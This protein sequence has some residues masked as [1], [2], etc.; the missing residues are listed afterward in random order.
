MCWKQ[1]CQHWTQR[2]ALRCSYRNRKGNICK[3]V[4]T[5]WY[6]DNMWLKVIVSWIR[7]LLEMRSG[8]TTISQSQ[9]SSPWSGNMWIPHWRKK[10]RCSL[11]R[12]K[13]CALSLG[14]EKG[15]DPSGFP[16]IISSDHYIMMLTKL[17]AWTSRTWPE[18][19]ATFLLQHDNARSHTT[20]KTMEHFANLY[21]TAWA[22]F[23]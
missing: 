14:I 17:K 10:W 5:Y 1:W 23:S 11:Q 4:R 13:W 19:E 21:L 18:T 3:F 15:C 7:S 20:L 8:V 2:W 16:G 9:N 6:P 22:T 12:V